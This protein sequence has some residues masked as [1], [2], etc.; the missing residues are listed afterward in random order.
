GMTLTFAGISMA[1]F[2]RENENERFR[3]KLA[4]VGVL[5]AFGGALGQAL[6]L[7]LSKFGMG[8]YDPFAATQIRIIAGIA[9]F[10]VLVTV[11]RRWPMVK[12]AI[13]N[14]PGMKS[15]TLGALFGPFLGVSFSLL[16]VKYTKTGIASTIMAL[17]PVFILLPA[18]MLYNEKVTKA[19][20][21]GAIIS[22]AG[23]ALFFV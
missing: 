19:E 2:S 23:V 6:G 10:T 14:V 13:R 7:V 21:A 5:Y 11:L 18:T 12:S 15:L 8:D 22:V 17:T 1:I 20:V 16:S 3:M 9:G 4:P